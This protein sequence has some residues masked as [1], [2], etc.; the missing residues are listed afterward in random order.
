[1]KLADIDGDNQAR[2]KSMERIP[3]DN[4][5][6]MIYAFDVNQNR[7]R[8]VYAKYVKLYPQLYIPVTHK[9]VEMV[10]EAAMAET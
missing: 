6:R 10:R 8:W 7:K 4:A 3:S 2:I 9:G 5:R 1:M